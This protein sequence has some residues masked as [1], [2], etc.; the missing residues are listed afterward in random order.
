MS[1][2]GNSV[3]DS[4]RLERDCLELYEGLKP[5]PVPLREVT[6]PEE[7]VVDLNTLRNKGRS[8]GIQAATMTTFC[9]ILSWRLAQLVTRRG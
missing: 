7:P 1:W 5:E 4:A 9:S 6:S 8:V 2:R 3:A